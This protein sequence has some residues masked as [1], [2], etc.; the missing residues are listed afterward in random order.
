MRLEYGTSES[1]EDI[2]IDMDQP[3]KGP[4]GETWYKEV[5]LEEVNRELRVLYAQRKKLEE[6]LRSILDHIHQPAMMS[7]HREDLYD[8]IR[9]LKAIARAAVGEGS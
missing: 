7:V 3:V 4:D 9:E 6:A 5:D 8:E 1:G 2:M